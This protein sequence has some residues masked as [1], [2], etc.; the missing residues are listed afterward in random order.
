MQRF[1]VDTKIDTGL[2]C[3]IYQNHSG[4]QGYAVVRF[5]PMGPND[6]WPSLAELNRYACVYVVLVG[7]NL[8]ISTYMYMPIHEQS[9]ALKSIAP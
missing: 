4:K 7:I 6:Y 2:G 3:K 8:N 5:N 1:F 9:H